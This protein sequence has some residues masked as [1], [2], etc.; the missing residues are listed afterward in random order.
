MILQKLRNKNLQIWS[1][2]EDDIPIT[3]FNSGLKRE[4]HHAYMCSSFQFTWLSL[5][6]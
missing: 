2:Y 6:K 3:N 5:Y 1:S 4:M